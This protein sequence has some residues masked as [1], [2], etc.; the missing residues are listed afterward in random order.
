MSAPPPPPNPPR[1]PLHERSSSQNNRLGIRIVPYSPPRL[2]SDGSTSSR[3]VSCTDVDALSPRPSRT[4]QSSVER[5]P[6][7]DCQTVPERDVSALRR[8]TGPVSPTL[9]PVD[10]QQTSIGAPALPSSPMRRSKNVITVNSDKTFS[11]LP[12]SHSV[13]SRSDSAR[14]PLSSLTTPRSSYGRYS[15][16]TWVEERPSSPLTPLAEHSLSP[17]SSPS[18]APGQSPN[19][20][21]PWN[22]RL[23]GG[24]RKVRKTPDPKATQSLHPIHSRSSSGASIRVL[25]VLVPQ[26]QGPQPSLSNKDSFQSSLSESTNSDTANYKVLG[27]SSPITRSTYAVQ[28]SS[29][30]EQDQP[31]PSSHSNY[32]VHHVSSSDSLSLNEPTRPPTGDSDA[33]YLIHRGSSS[34][35]ISSISRLRPEYSQESLVVAPLR[36]IRR[37]SFEFSNLVKSRSRDSLRTGSLTSLSTAISQEATRALFAGAATIQV[38]PRLYRQNSR[39]TLSGS[40]S[41]APQMITYPH[42]W[43]SQLS[44]VASE[45]EPGSE[46]PSRSVSSISAAERRSSGAPSSHGRRMLSISSALSGLEE[47]QSQSSHSRSGSLEQPLATYQRQT[48]RDLYSPPM[49]LVRDLD[50]DGDGLADLEALHHRPSRTRLNGT[51]SNRSSDRNL[52]SSSSSRANSFSSAAFPAWARY[53]YLC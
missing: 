25:P 38:P 40:S 20:T 13:S 8:S 17:D 11:L 2:S 7:S 6:G 29:D 9:S 33:N 4:R 41:H 34:S 14:S 42:Q 43:S 16:D 26:E 5:T 27:Q 50:E 36:P 44:T 35:L 30:V 45:S 51:L 21:S 53:D 46:P 10:E 22:Y 23:V 32:Q 39:G 24:L 37:R 18:P 47:A 15:S 48:P 28:D 12:Q 19:S 31:P 52:R 49:R 3:V 1:R